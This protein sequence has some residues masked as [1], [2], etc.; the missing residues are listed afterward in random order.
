MNGEGPWASVSRFY[1]S[2]DN[3]DIEAAVSPF[4]DELETT[5]RGYLHVPQLFR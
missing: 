2:F 4:S 5:D 3:G 1:E